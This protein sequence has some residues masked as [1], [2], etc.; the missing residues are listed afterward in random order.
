MENTS[1]ILDDI[2]PRVQK[3]AQYIGGEINSIAKSPESVD[4]SFALAFPDT[5]AIG[6]SHLGLQVLYGILNGR[7]DTAAERVFAPWPDMEEQMRSRGLPLFSLETRRPV[8]EFDIVAFSLQYEMCYSEVLRMLALA[9]VPLL[10]SERSGSDPLVI[11]GGPCAFN[12]EPMADFVDVFALG[13]GEE[14]IHLFTDTFKA[15][16][17]EGVARSEMLRRIAAAHRSFYVPSLYEV[18]YNADGTLAAITP[19]N[20]APPTVTKATVEDLNDAPAPTAPVVPYVEIVHD[21]IAIEIMRGC[22]QGCTF[23]QAARIKRPVRARS[24]DNII[25]I[26]RETYRNTGH[27]EIA[28]VSLSSSDYPDFRNLLAKITA[29]FTPLGVN[30]SLPSLRVTEQIREVPRYLSKVRKSGLTLAPEVAGD[31]LRKTLNKHVSNEDIYATAVEAFRAGWDLIKLYFMIGLPGE[32]K[33]DIDGIA[34]MVSEVSHLRR[35]VGKGPAR[36]N[37]AVST[38][39]PKPFTPLQRVRMTGIERIREVQ[40][41]LRQKVRARRIR[42]KFHS[43]ERSFLEGVFSR[44]DRRLGRVLLSAHKKGC[45]LDGWKETFRFDLWRKAFDECNIDPDFYATRE[46]AEDE[47]LPWSHIKTDKR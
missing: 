36:V 10:A 35:Q 27:D 42:L 3:P 16:R 41:Y 26:A 33:E 20:G 12:P 34:E 37:V 15:A 21:R 22:P 19:L 2:L 25:A 32:E 24:I 23:C 47:L 4:V 39:V 8:R 44:G 45:K 11:A 40:R 5:Y 14:T 1:K 38:F 46:R 43:P 29:E 13:D 17:K 18:A 30:I 31:S 28:L 7:D 6:M 9:G